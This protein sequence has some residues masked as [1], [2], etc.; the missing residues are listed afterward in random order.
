MYRLV[1]LL[2]LLALYLPAATAQNAAVYNIS[3]SNGLSTNHVYGTIIDKFGYLWMGTDNGVYRYN[4]YSLRK[5]D[6]NDGL[7]NI[8]VWNFY[9]DKKGRI[10]LLNISNQLGY[11]KNNKYTSVYTVPDSSMPEI[12]PFRVLEYKD[13]IIVLNKSHKLTNH[14]SVLIIE[15]DTLHHKSILRPGDGGRAG[16]WFLSDSAFID[17]G[18]NQKFIYNID[19]WLNDSINGN[20]YQLV[21][22][23]YTP[24]LQDIGISSLNGTFLNYIFY[25]QPQT[26]QLNILTYRNDKVKKLLFYD[27]LTSTP[28]TIIHAYPGAKNFYILCKKNIYILDK[29][30]DV[31]SSYS[32]LNTFYQS[33]LH[34]SKNTHY[35]ENTLWGKILCSNNSGIFINYQNNSFFKKTIPLDNY[36]YLGRIN[37]SAGYWVNL[38]TN[39]II[40]ISGGNVLSSIR[41][42]VIDPPKKVV[43]VAN[44]K[45]MVFVPGGIA[46][47]KSN[48][49]YKY[50][51]INERQQVFKPVYIDRSIDYKLLP[52]YCR[53]V[54]A[55]DTHEFYFTDTYHGT[56]KATINKD[57]V[58]IKKIY[59]DR[60]QH[61]AYNQKQ[62]L[63]IA[64]S[65]D[66]LLISN[67][68]KN[69]YYSFTDDQLAT[70]NIK[71]IEK[72]VVDDYANIYIKDYNSLIV[73]NFFNNRAKI[74]FSNYILEDAI[75][76]LQDKNLSIAGSFGVI[77]CSIYGPLQIHQRHIFPNTKNLF[78]NFV[79]DAQFTFSHILLNTDKGSYSIEKDNIQANIN[80]NDSFVT[81][82]Y[83]DS[84]QHILRDHD[85]IYFSQATAFADVDII[86]PTGTGV[87]KIIYS[88]NGGEYINSGYQVIVPKLSP[89]SYNIVSLIAYD[90]SW[91]SKPLTFYIYIQPYW[92]QTNTAKS[93]FITVFIILLF[94][95]IYLSV[96][97]TRKI[98]NRNNKRKNQR[99]EL[100]LKSIYS[101]INP[102]FIFNSL[103]T[104]QYFVKK[105]RN[106]EAF[107]HI[108][109]FS[110]LLR[111][112]I[113][114]SRDKYISIAEELNNLNNYLQLQLTRFEN[115]FEYRFEVDSTIEVSKIKIP[116]LLLQPLVENALNHGIFHSTYKGMLIIS[117]KKNEL[118][119]LVCIVDDNGI[120]RKRS[121]ELRTELTRKA[122][123][124][125]SILISELIDTFNKYESIKI[126][127]EYIDKELPQTGT[128]VLI[129]IKDKNNAQ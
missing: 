41:L 128:T 40:N 100:E 2:L 126:A 123:S 129:T 92:W 12:Y 80:S 13:K 69:T 88:I 47:I 18:F 61:L 55:I 118:G 91:R 24:L 81:T 72:I 120:G 22:G 97:A 4:G 83:V 30:A 38:A 64:Y 39:E 62:N 90:N 105:N 94:T 6:Y 51:R 20:S 27:T 45:A 56:L 26:N 23:N 58:L 107:E 14:T 25:A 10:W 113:K 35:T 50:I 124:Y 98:V 66:K 1:T 112:Y 7:A 111:A 53:D 108:S 79:V 65:K 110:D 5:Y 11:I 32:L 89:G 28:D 74:L 29:N 78:Y 48:E 104:A 95:I 46:F 106:K 57:T 101:Q 76:D 73:Y 70:L 121:K 34:A 85:T 75:I 42:P 127:I 82:I 43:P 3:K 114:L 125:G 102:H 103:S 16:G 63:L 60:Y 54:I 87:L 99:R 21:K 86:K 67:T 19:K 37:D 84:V 52:G 122:D 71:G 9:P 31:T 116:S 8:D 49:L 115:R 119:N 96:L 33:S 93:I 59:D 68:K 17:I 15:N 77:D 117:F 44:G 36:K 109:Q